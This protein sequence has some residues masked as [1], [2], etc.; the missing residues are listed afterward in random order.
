[1]KP[2]L[3]ALNIFLVG[4]IVFQACETTAP[5]PPVTSTCKDT[6]CQDY[7]NAPFIGLSANAAKDM[8]DAYYKDSSKSFIEFNGRNASYTEDAKSIW[9]SLE[10]LKKFI[11]NIEKSKCQG[12]NLTLGIRIYYAK[13]PDTNYMMNKLAVVNPQYSFHHTLFMVPTYFKTEVNRNVDFDPRFPGKDPCKPTSLKERFEKDILT[14]DSAGVIMFP[15]G[16]NGRS[17][18]SRAAAGLTDPTIQNHGDMAPPPRG[19]GTFPTN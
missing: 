5:C 16:Q 2:I 3:I 14:L 6:L 10:T 19:T 13:Y 17:N 4:I 7:S 1:M 12:C 8:A 9:F 15:T 18:F 11:W